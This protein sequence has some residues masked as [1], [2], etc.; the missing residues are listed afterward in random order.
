M[1]A[2]EWILKA[3]LDVCTTTKDSLLH[4]NE[5]MRELHSIMR[6][7]KGGEVELRTE[8]DFKKGGKKGHLKSLGKFE[9]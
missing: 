8:I 6:R 4:T 2:S 3:L 7:R 9:G 5:C 1:R